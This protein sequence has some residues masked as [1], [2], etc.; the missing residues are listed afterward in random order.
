MTNP[1][2][3]GHRSPRGGHGGGRGLP[4]MRERVAVLRGSM[5]AGPDGDDWTVAVRLPLKATR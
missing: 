4:G 3:P 5:I 1:L 2:T